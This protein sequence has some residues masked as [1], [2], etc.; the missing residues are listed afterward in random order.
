MIVHSSAIRSSRKLN[1]ALAT[2]LSIVLTICCVPAHAEP[3]KKTSSSSSTSKAAKAKKVNKATQTKK[4]AKVR[5]SAKVKK[6]RVTKTQMRRAQARKKSARGRV[7]STTPRRYAAVRNAQPARTFMD[8]SAGSLVL[9]SHAAFVV[10]Q[11]SGETL[12]TK[13]S[14]IEM[15][16]ASLTKLMT[17]LV[18]VEAKLPMD[19]ILEIGNEDVDREKNTH[20][21]LTVGTQLTRSE[22]L[23][24]ALMSSENRA[25]MSLS[26]HYPGGRPAFLAKMNAKAKALGMVS[27]HFADPAGLSSQSVSTARDL[28]RLV[29]AADAQPLIREYST[30]EESNVRVGRRTLKFINSNR[31]V[32]GGGDWDIGLQKTGFTN[33]AGR[34]LVMQVTLQGRRI[35]MVF[36]DSFGQLTRYADAMRVR[37]QL[38]RR[39]NTQPRLITTS[40]GISP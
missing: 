26:R 4:T 13:N 1:F 2:I 7:Y 16:I 3:T 25:A 30:H 33:E 39:L 19:E 40:A 23:L 22:M 28:H 34:C 38:E 12:V 6:V 10:D 14:D 31:L 15:P 20:S 11:D 29:S 32:R 18:V 35:A 21:R 37:Q 24:L 9:M 27:S 8:A 5:K 36:L 17:A